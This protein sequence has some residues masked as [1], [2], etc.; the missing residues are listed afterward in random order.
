MKVLF[1]CY[2]SIVEQHI[3]D[4]FK[5]AD[6]EVVQDTRNVREKN[7]PATQIVE[8][9]SGWL[10]KEQFLFVFSINFFPDVSN[11]C[12]IYG[13]PY[14]CW[15]VDSPFIQLFSPALKNKCN[16]IFFFDKAQYETFGRPL[17]STNGYYLPLAGNVARFQKTIGGASL[18]TKKKFCSDVSLVGSLY[19]EKNPYAKILNIPE[20]LKGYVDGIEQAQ[21]QV[22]GYN[23]IEDAITPSIIESF[24]KIIPDLRNSE[25]SLEIK[26]YKLAHFFI[27][28]D[29]AYH[30]RVTLLNALAENLGRE[31]TVDLYTL[32]DTSELR[33]V[34]NCGRA[35]S[36][37]EM[38][39]IFNQSKINLNITM[40]P[41]MT[42]LSQRVFDVLACGGFL[43]TNYQ[44]ELPEM[45]EIGEEVECFSSKE[46][47][48]EKT[49][50]YLEHDQLR[51]SIAEKGY[52]RVKNCYTFE[53]RFQQMLGDVLQTM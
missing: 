6:L 22:Y 51:R 38:P 23:L 44:E 7:V 28:S 36:F 33:N 10:K 53:H 9:M 43:L 18:Q 46:E 20:Y 35:Q 37:S 39:I 1:Y 8:D 13:V 48:F 42:G 4:C 27:G 40:R 29:L 34:R 15:T 25:E 30:E 32:S 3:I 24:S 12:E 19:N 47:L 52:E 21:M 50:F 14:V 49:K 2:D 11:V 31:Y 17:G 41:I 5:A 45:F 26:R 16:R